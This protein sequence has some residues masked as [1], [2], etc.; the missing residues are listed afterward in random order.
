[1]QT[2]G[3]LITLH[4][5]NALNFAANNSFLFSY[6]IQTSCIHKHVK[7]E[8]VF[9]DYVKESRVNLIKTLAKSFYY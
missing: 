2:D 5:I 3:F 6:Y 1:M 9:A 4:F 7:M 8:S